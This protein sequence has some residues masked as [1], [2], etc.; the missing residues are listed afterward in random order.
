M[1][2]KETNGAGRAFEILFEK[3]VLYMDRFLL[4]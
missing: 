3:T 4:E 2:A 1:T